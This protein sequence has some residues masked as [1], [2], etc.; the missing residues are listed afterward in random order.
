M[1]DMVIEL[2]WNKMGYPMDIPDAGKGKPK[3]RIATYNKDEKDA[4][5]QSLGVWKADIKKRV[6]DMLKI[7]TTSEGKYRIGG[8]NYKPN[9]AERHITEDNLPSDSDANSETYSSSS[10][11]ESGD[12]E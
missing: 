7:G 1:A 12:S 10:Y 11:D 3:L 9:Y 6:C 8:G 4:W 2:G 5:E